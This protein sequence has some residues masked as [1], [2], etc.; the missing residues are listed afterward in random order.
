MITSDRLTEEMSRKLRQDK[1]AYFT[2]M[3][4]EFVSV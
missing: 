1:C 2:V 3:H 4:I